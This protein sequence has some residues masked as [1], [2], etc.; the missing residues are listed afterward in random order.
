VW[1]LDADGTPTLQL[2]NVHVS[3]G[4]TIPFNRGDWSPDMS[5]VVIMDGAADTAF[6]VVNADNSGYTVITPSGMTHS[7]AN[8]GLAW[9]P[10]GTKIA[11]LFGAGSPDEEFGVATIAPDGSG[12]ATVFAAD[13]GLTYVPWDWYSDNANLLML[14]SDPTTAPVDLIQSDGSTTT[15]LYTDPAGGDPTST[16]S[17]TALA[18]NQ[19]DAAWNSETG[20]LDGFISSSFATVLAHTGSNQVYSFGGGWIA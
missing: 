5:Q 4:G 11:F 18:P 10:D 16:G 17:W 9:S 2:T 1:I 19:T 20:A 12:Q 13:T 6:Q 14:R 15:V 8:F 3:G 7:G